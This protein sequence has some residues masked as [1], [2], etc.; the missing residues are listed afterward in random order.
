MKLISKI[1]CTEKNE[2]NIYVVS[3]RIV[4]LVLY[5]GAGCA[6]LCP[7]FAYG[8]LVDNNEK[9]ND[10]FEFVPFVLVFLALELIQ[11]LVMQ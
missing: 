5:S 1:Y 8:G 4:G 7:T 11:H 2:G 3:L 10:F 9:S 6:F